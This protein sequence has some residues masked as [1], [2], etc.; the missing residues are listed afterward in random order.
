MTID[1]DDKACCRDRKL[2]LLMCTSTW[3]KIII[4]IQGHYCDQCAKV[5]S[6]MRIGCQ[7]SSII[8]AIKYLC[9]NN[10]RLQIFH[11]L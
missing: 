1:V 10:H 6:L 7:S 11:T 9:K 3:K 5:Q 2:I 4:R 8:I